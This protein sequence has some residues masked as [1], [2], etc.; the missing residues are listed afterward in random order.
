MCGSSPNP[1][2][3][4][5]VSKKSCTHLYLM[6]ANRSPPALS[7]FDKVLNPLSTLLQSLPGEHAHEGS[8]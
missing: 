2:L 7:A 1:W 3:T 6:K 4:A 5:T 8:F